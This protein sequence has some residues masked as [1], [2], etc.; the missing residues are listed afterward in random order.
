MAVSHAIALDG[1]S[2]RYTT[3][4]R[5]STL[6]LQNVSLKAA[7]GEF[8]ALVGPS[9]CGKSTLLKLVAGLTMPSK[10]TIE[11]FG[12]KITAPIKS[13][14]IVF[15]SPVLMKWRTVYENVAL[16]LEVLGIK[17]NQGP[18]PVLALL[19]LAGIQDFAN[20]YPNEL[21]GGM[22]Q[23]V[24]ICRSLVHNP[25]LLLLDEPFGALDA[26]TRSRMNVDLAKILAR[27]KKTTILITHSVSEAV[28]LADRVVVLS[29]RPGKIQEIVDVPIKRP[30]TVD[31]RS[32]REF[33]ELVQ[34]IG[35]YIGFEFM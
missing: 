4:G 6:A 29:A 17:K 2:K 9:G 27:M 25:R 12:S 13:A 10:G 11:V 22:Q 14:G 20:S 5:S 7:E 3:S 30:R 19:E 15:Q 32:T 23:R 24:S 8:V 18:D 1:V 28:F 26:M 33:G 21:S 31:I 34:K 16:P 35:S